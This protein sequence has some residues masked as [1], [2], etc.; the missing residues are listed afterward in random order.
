MPSFDAQLQLVPEDGFAL[1]D[2]AEVKRL[3][4]AAHTGAADA[5]TG[6]RPSVFWNRQNF[7][8]K[9]GTRKLSLAPRE[10]GEPNND[11]F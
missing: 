1:G 5:I 11:G 4:H 8:L 6:R 10:H 3:S 9:I 7:S 2:L